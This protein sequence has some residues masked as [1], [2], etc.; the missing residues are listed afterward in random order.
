VPLSVKFGGA[1][2]KFK[3]ANATGNQV[4][5]GSVNGLTLSTLLTKLAVPEEQQL[6]VIVNSEVIPSESYATTTLS[7]DDVVSLMP[8]I[9][10]G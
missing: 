10:A 1:L 3:P 6:L 5:I 8:P 2:V 7:D 9:Q 4:T